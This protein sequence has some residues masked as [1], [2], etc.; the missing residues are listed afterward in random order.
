[1]HHVFRSAMILSAVLAVVVTA[2]ALAQKGAKQQERAAKRAADNPIFQVPKKITLSAEQQAKLQ[3]IKDEYAPKL[4]A[5]TAKQNEILT[6]EQRKARAEVTKANREAKK[7]GKQAQEAVAAALKLTDEQ[8]QK[9]TA[10]QKDMQAL[11]K[12]IEQ[13]KRALL[14]PEQQ[15]MLPK[16]GGNKK[17]KN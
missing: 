15:A 14:T 3:A 12:E 1:M 5:I 4:A 17:P 13:K 10:T 8:Q 7:T 9:W 11:R 16:Q 6:P 2:P